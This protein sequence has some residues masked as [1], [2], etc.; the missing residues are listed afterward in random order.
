[1][2]RLTVYVPEDLAEWARAAD[3]NVS[4]LAQ[5]AL[6]AE[7]RRRDHD[8]WLAGLERRPARRLASQRIV[9]AVSEVRDELDDA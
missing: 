2:P 3:V 9:D 4:R 7:R 1:M 6:R 8:A 5:D